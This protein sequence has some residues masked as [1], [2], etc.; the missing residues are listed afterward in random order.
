MISAQ[1]LS[2]R[3]EYKSIS[4]DVLVLVSQVHQQS[5][6]NVLREIKARIKVL[7]K[8]YTGDQYR[9]LTHEAE[10]LRHVLQSYRMMFHAQIAE[11]LYLEAK[12]RKT[13][14]VAAILDRLE[15]NIQIAVQEGGRVLSTRI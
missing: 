11:Q 3:Q 5:A 9:Q 13:I 15:R 6:M 8:S 1:R 12:K 4:M 2:P 10:S 14:E 7:R